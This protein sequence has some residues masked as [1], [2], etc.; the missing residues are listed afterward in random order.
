MEGKEEPEQKQLKILKCTEC[1][2]EY[3]F[4]SVSKYCP[5]CRGLLKEETI[6]R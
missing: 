6:A 5:E 4:D 1:G 3:I 2:K